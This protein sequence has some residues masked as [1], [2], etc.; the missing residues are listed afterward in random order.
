MTLP[1][2]FE[3]NTPDMVVSFLGVINEGSQRLS[4]EL[5]LNEKQLW[6]STL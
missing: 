5:N 1:D 3:R 4:L 6:T 2:R